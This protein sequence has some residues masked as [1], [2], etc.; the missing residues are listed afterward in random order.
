[1]AALTS[2]DIRPDFRY[3]VLSGRMD[4]QGTEA[5]EEQV[6]GLI[7]GSNMTIIINVAEVTFLASIGIRMLIASGKALKKNGGR[8]ALV[9][10]QNAS[11]IKTVKATC[12]DAIFPLCETYEQAEAAVSA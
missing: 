10:G 12:G 5:V 8:I 9:V 4:I 1:M 7:S 11:V 2:K 3:I 6:K